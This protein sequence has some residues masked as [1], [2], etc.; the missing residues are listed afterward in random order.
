MLC[1]GT[2]TQKHMCTL[3][4][5]Q[6]YTARHT[7]NCPQEHTH[8]QRHNQMILLTITYAYAQILTHTH[9]DTNGGCTM[10]NRHTHREKCTMLYMH[11]E[12][13]KGTSKNM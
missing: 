8:A 3:R 5:T 12:R 11:I 1:T 4:N 2:H 6:V 13:R 10:T 9:G 7:G